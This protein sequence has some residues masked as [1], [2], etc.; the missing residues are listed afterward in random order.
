[1]MRRAATGWRSSRTVRRWLL[2]E[3]HEAHATL[4]AAAV[5]G[6]R[7]MRVERRDCRT[8]LGVGLSCDTF[9]VA[10]VNTSMFTVVRAG[11]AVAPTCRARRVYRCGVARTCIRL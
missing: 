1:M 8:A 4:P 10:M 9:A 6:R 3:R 2:P 11:Q 7:C 5:A